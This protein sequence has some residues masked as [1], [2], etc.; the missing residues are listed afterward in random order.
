MA[1]LNE[2]DLDIIQ[3]QLAVLET[4]SVAFTSKMYD[5]FVSTTPMDVELN[6]WVYD[7]EGNSSQ[8]VMDTIKLP[9]RAKGNIPS[10]YG[11][12]NPSTGGVEASLGTIYVDT[13]TNTI[14]IKKT[15][16]GSDGW[17]R[18]ITEQEM[19][20]HNDSDAAHDGHLAKVEGDK[21]RHFKVADVSED[22]LNEFPEIFGDYAVNMRSLDNL[23]GGTKNLQTLD[24]TNIVNS[25]NE[26]VESNAY[27][28]GC[29]VW[30]NAKDEL[31]NEPTIFAITDPN[32]NDQLKITFRTF[33]ATA[34]DG[35]KHLFNCDHM[36]AG[37]PITTIDSNATYSVYA[38]PGFGVTNG[39]IDRTKPDWTRAMIAFVR[40]RFNKSVNKPYVSAKWDGWMDL[41]SIPYDFKLM[42][43]NDITGKLEY[44]D[45][46][47]LALNNDGARK[48]FI[49]AKCY[50]DAVFDADPDD[51][52]YSKNSIETKDFIYLGTIER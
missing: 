32:G 2:I 37:L 46:V 34:P 27:D 12:G 45:T 1:Q 38:I 5:L 9:N 39:K 40:G 14:Y 4:N 23:L 19:K 42:G 48:N 31:T 35:R 17:S 11:E 28:A 51:P 26:L 49:I 33:I 6:V 20:D 52:W 50:A 13:T 16:G 41:S 44:V 47:P 21:T 22:E 43:T 30:S 10:K 7:K 29:V 24:Q 25:I 36:G 15:N 3:K 8:L 18:L